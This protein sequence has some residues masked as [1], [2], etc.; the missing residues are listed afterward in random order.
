M[1]HPGID[2]IL[3]KRP[4]LELVQGDLYSISQRIKEIEAGY[5]IVFNKRSETY[6]VHSTYNEGW[7]TY[8]FSVPYDR[9]DCRTLQLCRETNIAMHGDDIMK[10]M[11]GHNEKLEKTNKRDFNRQMNDAGYETADMVSLGIEKDELHE[12]YARTHYMG[13]GVSK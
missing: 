10:Q 2:S 7:N 8:C 9:L 11:D 6:E 5:F 13:E 4:Y 3:L 12:G 1:N